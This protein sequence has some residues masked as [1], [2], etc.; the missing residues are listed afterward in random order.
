LHTY[1]G[2]SSLNQ[3]I[4]YFW[5]QIG[6]VIDNDVVMARLFIGTLKG[7]AFDSFRSP[8]NGAIHFWVDLKTQ[9][10]SRFYEDDTRVTMDKLL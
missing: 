2:K 3:H 7:M 1:N 6:N 5:L 9:F 8:P 4:Y 10:L